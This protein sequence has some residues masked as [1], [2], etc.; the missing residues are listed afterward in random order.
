[1]STRLIPMETEMLDWSAHD[2]CDHVPNAESIATM[3]ECEEIIRQIEAG[4][5]TPKFNSVAELM[6]DLMAEDDEDNEIWDRAV[7]KIPTAV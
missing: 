4:E 6:A 5:R 1:M 7:N 2:N 3:Q